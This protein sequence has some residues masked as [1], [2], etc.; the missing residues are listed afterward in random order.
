MRN[1]V[2]AMRTLSVYVLH[3]RLFCV[4]LFIYL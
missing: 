1:M 3:A 2:P 4:G